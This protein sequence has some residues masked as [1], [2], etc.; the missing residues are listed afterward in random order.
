MSVCG[1]NFRNLRKK[2]L[3]NL[4]QSKLFELFMKHA[5]YDWRL[6]FEHALKKFLND[7][8]IQRQKAK[9]V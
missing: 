2:F 8:N 7:K 1:P 3:K 6:I 5:K 9:V 4:I